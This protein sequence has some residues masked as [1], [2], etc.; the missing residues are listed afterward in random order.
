MALN[1]NDPRPIGMPE[2][3]RYRRIWTWYKANASRVASR[4]D[5]YGKR[6]YDYIRGL[7]D[8]DSASAAQIADAF[9]QVQTN[10]LEWAYHETDGE[11]KM[12]AY[13]GA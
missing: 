7:P 5:D 8:P 9:K 6:S 4:T 11:Y 10:L 2:R 1:P 12:A 13:A 3:E